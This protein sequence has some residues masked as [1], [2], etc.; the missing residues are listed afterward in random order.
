MKQLWSA[1][2]F[3]AVSFFVTAFVDLA[4][5]ETAA[6]APRPN[7]IWIMADDLGYG[8]LGCYGQKVIQTPHLDRMAQEGLRF[9]RFYAG[10]TVCAPSRSV[11]M[12]GQHHGHTRVR[13]NAG[14]GNP[15]AQ[16]LRQEDVTVA[17]VLNDAGYAT[18]LIGKWGL[19]DVHGAL[20]GLPR[21]QGFDYF[22]GYLNQRHA[23]NHYPTFLWRNEEEDFLGNA[24]VKI[25]AV[26]AGYTTSPEDSLEYA[27]D[28]F[29]DEAL[30]YVEEHKAAPFFLYWSMVVPHANNERNGGLKDGTEVPDLGLYADRDWPAQDKGQA[31]MITRMDSYVG[32]MLDKLKA[33]GIDQ[34]TLVIFT[35]DNGPHNESSHDLKRFN[36]SGPLTGIKRSLTDGGIRVPTIARW[37]GRIAAGVTT[38]HVAYFGDWMATAAELVGTKTPDGCDSISFVPTLEGHASQ[39]RSHEF[40]YWEFHERGFSQ[41][42]LYQGRWKGIR[43]RR[44]DAPLVLYDLQTDL[45]EQTDV[46]ASHPDI[47][48]KIDAYLKTARTES[49]DWP[50]KPAPVGGKNQR[51]ARN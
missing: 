7:L 22:Y 39:Q 48:A 27:D 9:T 1:V 30:K 20:P 29:A 6:A 18:A 46:A 24:I 3:L 38:G 4:A 15:L 21:K 44:P 40:L 19:G 23:H 26:G 11:L 41:A 25:D 34:N 42:A 31:A 35:S 14:A 2:L 10:A 33:L 49:P 12:T 28:L 16:S 13:G 51:Q 50:I 37:P 43:E 45:G 5:S 47:V 36:P 8:D 32:R 17:R